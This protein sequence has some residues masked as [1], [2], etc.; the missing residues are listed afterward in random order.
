[1]KRLILSIAI[2]LAFIG[3]A[4][5]QQQ[6][7]Q[8]TDAGQAVANQIGMLFMQNAALTE[9]VQRQ[10]MTISRLQKELADAKA[11]A[12]APKPDDGK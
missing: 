8:P 5:A 1:M 2:L 9:Q 6:P 10:Q 4:Y 11:V 7:Q 3:A 12:S